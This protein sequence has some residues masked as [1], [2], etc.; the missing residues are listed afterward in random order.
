MGLLKKTEISNFQELENRAA[1]SFI[2]EE[3]HNVENSSF[4]SPIKTLIQ[5]LGWKTVNEMV[6][7][8]NKAIVYRS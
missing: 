6:K 7:N 1:R 2:A 4:S 8:D 3:H 5:N